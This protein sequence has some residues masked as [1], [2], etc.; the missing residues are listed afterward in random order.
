M[1][2]RIAIIGGLILAFLVLPRFTHADD[3]LCGPEV[4]DEGT[5]TW[6]HEGDP[7]DE[8][9]CIQLTGSLDVDIDNKLPYGFEGAAEIELLLQPGGIASVA[10]FYWPGCKG[11]GFFLG[12]SCT[13]QTPSSWSVSVGKTGTFT[14]HD[15][16]I[17]VIFFTSS[18]PMHTTPVATIFEVEA[19]HTVV[20]AFDNFE[21][22]SEL[23]FGGDGGAT[24]G[25]DP[26]DATIEGL[27]EVTPPGTYGILE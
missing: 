5:V 13:A 27:F 21:G 3:P 18:D 24:L 15:L 23:Q 9:I 10:S 25:S 19:E 8:S 6:T 7:L 11:T 26:T 2:N 4:E 17:D 14:I 20:G 22:F 16:A 1:K 12:L